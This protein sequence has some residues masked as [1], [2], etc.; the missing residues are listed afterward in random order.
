MTVFGGHSR[1]AATRGRLGQRHLERSG[2]L[3]GLPG[4]GLALKCDE[5]AP[6]VRL[7][8]RRLV[9]GDLDVLI[10]ACALSRLAYDVSSPGGDLARK[11]RALN[12]GTFVD[13]SP[14]NAKKASLGWFACDCLLSGEE[15]R[16]VAIRGTERI[17]DWA[18]NLDFEPV[19]FEARWAFRQKHPVLV[20]RGFY[21]AAR[22]LLRDSRLRA[23]VARAAEAGRRVAFT[24]HSMG[25]TVAVLLAL[26]LAQRGLLKASR[27]SGVYGFGSTEALCARARHFTARFGLDRHKFVNVMNLHDIVPRL[28]SCACPEFME[29]IVLEG[30]VGGFRFNP[31]ARLLWA[32]GLPKPNPDRWRRHAAF[33]ETSRLC[34]PLGVLVHLVPDGQHGEGLRGDV[35]EEFGEMHAAL[36]APGLGAIVRGGGNILSLHNSDAYTAALRNAQRWI[37]LGGATLAAAQDG[38]GDVQGGTRRA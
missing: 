6:G 11:L 23:V 31:Y 7:R 26:L 2:S 3:R 12:N 36:D 35:L 24:G 10:Q 29:K 20:H 16:V 32:L 8:G 21:R 34:E 14:G 4:L 28:T 13:S 27:L 9:S 33:L 1:A 17:S 22:K 15:T 25:G 19:P 18:V 38:G 30:S 5:G 37:E